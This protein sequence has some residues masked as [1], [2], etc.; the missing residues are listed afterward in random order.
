MIGEISVHGL[1]IYPP[2]IIVGAFIG[3]M[4]RENYAPKFHGA[5]QPQD[6]RSN[7]EFMDWD[8]AENRNLAVTAVAL[9]G[10]AFVGEILGPPLAREIIPALEGLNDIEQFIV[11]FVSTLIF[12]KLYSWHYRSKHKSD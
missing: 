7:N 9:F 10:G 4:I 12:L 6:P 5:D 8:T 11:V 2:G 3:W 1:A